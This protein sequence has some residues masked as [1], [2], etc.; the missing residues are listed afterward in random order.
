MY[1][2][3]NSIVSV[4]IEIANK[5]FT[6]LLQ[7]EVEGV[8]KENIKCLKALVESGVGGHKG[9][10]SVK[11]LRGKYDYEINRPSSLPFISYTTAVLVT[12]LSGIVFL[13]MSWRYSS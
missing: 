6:L 2:F 1:F 3:H 11:Q 10:K 4:N 8:C 9:E 5:C 7:M 12:A 13:F